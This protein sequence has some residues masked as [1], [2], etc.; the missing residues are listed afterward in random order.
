[1][2]DFDE[3]VCAECGQEIVS[4]PPCDPPPTI[5]ATCQWLDE[6]I[7]DPVERERLRQRLTPHA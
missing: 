2:P 6:F 1:M 4:L 7:S 5:C 3:F